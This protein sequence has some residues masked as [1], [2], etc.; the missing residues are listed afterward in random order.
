MI[1]LHHHR[2]EHK[3]AFKEDLG[4]VSPPRGPHQ[5]S[6]PAQVDLLTLVQHW[7]HRHVI[8]GKLVILSLVFDVSWTFS[9]AFVLVGISYG[10]N[11]GLWALAAHSYEGV[12]L[13]AASKAESVGAKKTRKDFLFRQVCL[14]QL[15]SNQRK[16]ILDLQLSTTA[17]HGNWISALITGGISHHVEHHLFPRVSYI[18]LHKVSIWLIWFNSASFFNCRSAP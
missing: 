8:G 11:M 18:H 15:P 16:F 2:E 1:S 5:P 4:E 7:I 6:V 9:Q 17:T 14:R 13:D 10:F 12:L 3:E